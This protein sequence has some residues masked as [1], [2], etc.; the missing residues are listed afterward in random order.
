MAVGG[1]QLQFSGARALVFA[2]RRSWSTREHDVKPDL[3]VSK[4]DAQM[5]VDRAVA[6]RSVA[7]IANI[8]GGAISALF[9]IAFGGGQPPLMLKVYPDD[10]HWKMRKEVTVS[11]LI[12]NRLTVPVPRILLADDTKS[13]LGFNFMLMDKLH[14]DVLRYLKPSPTAQETSSVYTRIGQVL[15]ELHRIA[16]TAFGYI[17]PDGVWTPHSSNY[18]YMSYQFEKKLR[19]FTELGGSPAT[20]ER[21]AAFIDARNYLL[22]ECAIPVLCHNDLH[23]EN[24]LVTRDGTLRVSGIVD[25]EGALAGDPLVDVAKALYYER[26]DNQKVAALLGG[27]GPMERHRWMGTIDL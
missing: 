22:R 11:S 12:Q 13:V 3:V 25:F 18:A 8:Q 23:S 10:L 6:G 17:G 27:Y 20:T 14:G 26:S 5:I 16:M 19:E 15:R 4:A 24:V 1:E 7:A 9:E 2:T 21:V